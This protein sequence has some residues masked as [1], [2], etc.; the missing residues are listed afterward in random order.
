M[1]ALTQK[2]IL[3]MTSMP[4][5]VSLAQY[6][7]PVDT[8]VP[9]PVLTGALHFGT[10]QQRAQLFGELLIPRF[11]RDTAKVR[12]RSSGNE[13]LRVFDTSIGFGQPYPSATFV[14]A[15]EEFEMALLGFKYG[16]DRIQVQSF[17]DQ[18]FELTL[19]AAER[20]EWAIKM[21]EE[22]R[23]AL[24]FGTPTNYPVLHRLDANAAEWDAVG[25]DSRADIR[26]I[27]T[28]I[29]LAHPGFSRRNFKIQLT[30]SAWEAAQG[31]PTWGAIRDNTTQ[32]A[33]D[34]ASFE[35][36]LGYVPG[37]VTIA[38]TNVNDEGTLRSLWDEAAILTLDTGTPEVINPF[39]V[40][41]FGLNHD[42]GVTNIFP[43]W[44]EDD[45]RTDWYPVTRSILPV[46][47]D[48]TLG[49]IIFNQKA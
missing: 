34:P 10:G 38:D 44:F 14:E 23:L 8:L 18:I 31:D 32:D 41:V 49:G 36:Y 40:N 19:G 9:D 3:E 17:A 28:Q 4:T 12:I 42:M 46:A 16:L 45:K 39:G 25:G 27:E 48:L 43:S 30:L 35:R 47:H 26:T 11:P 29:L 24:L 21:D 2:Q 15:T 7:G 20:A 33:P 6:A 22:N 13:H 1:L 5:G 37:A